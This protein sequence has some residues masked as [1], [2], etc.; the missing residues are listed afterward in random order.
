MKAGFEGAQMEGDRNMRVKAW[1]AKTRKGE[2]GWGWGQG[3]GG[4]GVL[5]LQAWSMRSLSSLMVSSLRVRLPCRDL[6]R[7]SAVCTSMEWSAAL[8]ARSAASKSS[9]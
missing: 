7:D 2:G 9:T 6:T 4:G 3:E 1:W 8:A 5:Y